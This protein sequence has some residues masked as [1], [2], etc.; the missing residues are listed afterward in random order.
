MVTVD[1]DITLNKQA[2]IE[3]LKKTRATLYGQMDSAKGKKKFKSMR[4]N[5]KLQ[6]EVFWQ[7]QLIALD[8]AVVA[9]NQVD[10]VS[11]S[12]RGYKHDHAM[13]VVGT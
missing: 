4:P 11:F 2:V 5:E 7:Q 6:L 10:P 1:P 13:P 12:A 9:L 3:T 8:I